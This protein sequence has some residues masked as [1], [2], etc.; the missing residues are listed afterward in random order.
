MVHRGTVP[1]DRTARSARP[2]LPLVLAVAGLLLTLGVLGVE[3]ATGTLPGRCEQFAADS[4]ARAEAV[5]GSGADVLVVGDSWTAG[6]GLDD[7]V[8]SW[9]SRLPGRVHTAG[10]SGS[11]FGAGA[12]GCGPRVSFGARAADAIRTVPAGTPVVV[13]GGLN[14]WDSSDAEVEAG[15]DRVLAATAGHP[16]TVV[17]PANAPARS[18]YVARVEGLLERL[19]AERG[20]RFV[21]VS[22]LR[23]DYLPDLLHLTPAG[24]AAFGD[25]VA[26]RLSS[27][28]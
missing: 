10:F 19:C 8:R 21:G 18:A 13:A 6:L 4:V 23:L 1:G 22:D 25:A 24:H 14:D 15:L 17:G 7:P 5:T 26:A 9:P 2:R 16:V 3:R 27:G 20:V 12:S 11:G 28:G